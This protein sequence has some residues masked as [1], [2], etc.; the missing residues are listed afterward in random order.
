MSQTFNQAG[1]G[2]MGKRKAISKKTRFEVFKRDGFT[3]AYCGGQPPKVVLHCD[4]IVPVAEDGTNDIDNL[5]TA[6]DACN[7]GKGA[8]S[9]A[10][11]PKTVAEKADILREKEDQIAGFNALI[12]E[13]Q[14]RIE[15]TAWDIA[16]ALN[17]AWGLERDCFNKRWLASIIQF[18]D[19]LALNDLL[20][21]VVIATARKPYSETQCFKYFCGIC[22]N[23]IRGE[24]ADG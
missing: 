20:E 13:R 15:D 4:H 1:G 18:A 17:D 3:C 14:N 6:C 10:A 11:L 16:N 8:R 24:R 12:A 2:G 23:K 5:V 19:K 22:W 21:A 9:L 7:L